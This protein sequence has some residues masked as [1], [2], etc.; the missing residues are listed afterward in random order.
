MTDPTTDLC[1]AC[2]LIPF[3]SLGLC[4]IQ[5]DRYH[6]SNPRPRENGGTKEAWADSPAPPSAAAVEEKRECE[7]R[8]GEARRQDVIVCGWGVGE[9]VPVPSSPRAVWRACF[10]PSPV[11]RSLLLLSSHPCRVSVGVWWRPTPGKEHRALTPLSIWGQLPGPCSSLPGSQG[12]KQPSPRE[13]VTH[14]AAAKPTLSAGEAAT[15][16]RGA[17]SEAFWSS[18]STQDRAGFQQRLGGEL[19]E[20]EGNR[21]P[22]HSSQ[23]SPDSISAQESAV[24][25]QTRS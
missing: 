1:A 22:R 8:A 23:Q 19:G 20:E 4:W 6:E 25:T 14:P 5:Y 12:L 9:C 13:T 21:F 24:T 18:K 17:H 7:C 10:P 16:Y 3:V 11:R 2:S 15:G